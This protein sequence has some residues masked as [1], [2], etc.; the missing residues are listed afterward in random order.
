MSRD[1]SNALSAPSTQTN[2]GSRSHHPASPESASSHL[3]SQND[4]NVNGIDGHA[5]DPSSLSFVESFRPSDNQRSQSFSTWMRSPQDCFPSLALQD[6]GPPSPPIPNHNPPLTSQKRKQT[7]SLNPAA[8]GGYGPIP[9]SQYEL[10]DRS[11]PDPSPVIQFTRRKNSAYDVW[12]FTRAVATNVVVPAEQ[13]PDDYD[14]YL[15][16]RPGTEFVGCKLCTQFG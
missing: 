3:P 9:G 12:V 15:T 11:T 8:V 1:A 13:W 14:D 7:T 6:P 10:S 4:R 16:K 2:M 5:Y